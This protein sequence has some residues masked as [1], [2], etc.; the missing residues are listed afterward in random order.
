MVGRGIVPQVVLMALPLDVALFEGDNLL[1][2]SHRRCERG[3]LRKIFGF[4]ER[5]LE[6]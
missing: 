1:F 4:G 5:D 2:R 6:L 3:F